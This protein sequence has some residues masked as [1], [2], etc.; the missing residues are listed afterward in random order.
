MGDVS[1]PEGRA[2]GRRPWQEEAE[3]LRLGSRLL[4]RP[5]RER[6]GERD[7]PPGLRAA[8][9]AAAAAAAAKDVCALCPVQP[10]CLRHALRVGEPYGVWGGLDEGERRRLVA[11]RA[12]R[13]A[14]PSSA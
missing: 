5:A 7:G 13:P 3:C 2:A 4:F 1:R 9:A 6:G 10:E 14:L 11:A 8:G 12:E